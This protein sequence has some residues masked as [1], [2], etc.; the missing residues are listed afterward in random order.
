MDDNTGENVDWR[1]KAGQLGA[2]VLRLERELDT[3][4]AEVVLLTARV[5]EL[6][7]KLNTALEY[8]I[9]N[10]STPVEYQLMC[11]LRGDEGGGESR[12]T[13]GN[14]VAGIQSGDVSATSPWPAPS[15]DDKP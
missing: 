7:K 5:R 3:A 11:I 10:A 1:M 12:D 6:N 13:D 4:N 9:D 2:C 14:D 8:V 15:P